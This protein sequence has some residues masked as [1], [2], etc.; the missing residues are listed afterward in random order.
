MNDITMEIIQLDE[1]ERDDTAIITID[2][3]TQIR[4]DFPIGHNIDDY[5]ITIS[6]GDGWEKIPSK[7]QLA[8]DK[9]IEKDD[10][11]RLKEQ[12]VPTYVSK[13]VISAATWVQPCKP[14]KHMDGT[15]SVITITGDYLHTEFDYNVDYLISQQHPDLTANYYR[16]KAI[17]IIKGELVKFE[18]LE[19]LKP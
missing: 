19:E 1:H 13:D 8:M 17:D 3:N 14:I 9:E 11:E 10:L 18:I 15:S 7:S 12:L 2:E 5:C 6:R 16:A 4:V